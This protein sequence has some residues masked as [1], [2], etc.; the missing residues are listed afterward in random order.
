[1]L[2]K[3]A[4]LVLA[5]FLA[6]S[7][8]AYAASGALTD[9]KGDYPDIVKLAYDNGDSKVVMTA[10][11]A[12]D[13][14]NGRAQ[15]ESL[16]MRWGSSAQKYYQVFLSAPDSTKELRYSGSSRK[17]ACRGLRVKHPTA[18]S[19]KV[20]VPRSC[21]GKAPDKLRFQAIAT[22]GLFSKD[23]TKVSKAVARG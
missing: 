19:T 22:E 14:M 4:T 11:Y 13:G 2:R 18:R 21:I 6:S 15:N 5:A 16:Y 9:P 20:I 17:V 23:E 7:A 12:G 10:T 8:T 1:M 3:E